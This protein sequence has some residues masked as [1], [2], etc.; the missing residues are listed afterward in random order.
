MIGFIGIT[1]QLQSIITAHTLNSFW[2]PYE[3]PLWRISHESLTAFWLISA[4]LEFTNPLRFITS[5][6]PG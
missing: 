5:T 3:E 6:R 1:L 2:K 4:S